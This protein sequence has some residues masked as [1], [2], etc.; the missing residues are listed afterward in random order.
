MENAELP[1]SWLTCLPA[2][3]RFAC[4][5]HSS[6]AWDLYNVCATSNLDRGNL[7]IAPNWVMG[8]ERSVMRSK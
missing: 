3:N 8:T 5:T 7:S 2:Q 1:P 4:H 6:I